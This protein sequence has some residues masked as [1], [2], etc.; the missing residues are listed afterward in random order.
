MLY[1]QVTWG[2]WRLSSARQ[3]NAIYNIYILNV[4]ALDETI[5][6]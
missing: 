5:I 3:R 6:P 2:L 4:A 1:M